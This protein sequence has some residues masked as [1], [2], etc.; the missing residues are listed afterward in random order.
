[1]TA[2]EYR[3][4]NSKLMAEYETSVR[5]WLKEKGKDSISEKIPFFRDGVVS[6]E[7]W[8]EKGNEFRPMIILKEVSLG[9][10]EVEKLD[11]YLAVWGN[12]KHFEFVENP[13]DDVRIGIFKQWRRIARLLK[14]LEDV[15]YGEEIQDYYKY[16]FDYMPGNEIYTGPIEGYKTDG[17]KSGRT[18]N[19]LY[20]DIISKMAL[21]EI[22]KVGGGTK[23]GTNLSLESIHYIEHIEPFKELMIKQIKLINP[24]VIIC[25]GVENKQ[26]ISG[27]LSEIREKTGDRIW[28]DGC[29]HTRSSNA[30]FYYK[31]IE[32]FRQCLKNMSL[33]VI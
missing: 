19:P 14:G 10:D 11:D 13:F 8:F 30:N 3:K 9:V 32:E 18:A 4:E 21:F 16:N 6:P 22:K 2:N 1:M 27:L 26:C 5:K 28:I 31:P 20:N 24:T 25:C 33:T 12:Q 29:H 17:Y 15:F 23:V 7:K